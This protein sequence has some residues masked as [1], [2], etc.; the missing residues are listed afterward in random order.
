V[1]VL[2]YAQPARE[3]IE[4][5]PIGNGLQGAMLFGGID[6]ERIQINEGTAWSGSTRSERLPPVVPAE[7]AA[8]AV[9]R[10]RAALRRGDHS[11]A[12]AQVRRLQH[13]YS[14]TF[15]PFA[16]LEV[17]LKP[18]GRGAWA[19]PARRYAR[20]LDLDA[21]LHTVRYH[22]DGIAVAQTAFASWPDRV[23]VHRVRTDRPV[24]V[25]LVL[26]SPLRTLSWFAPGGVDHGSEVLMELGL[27]LQL[28]SD[29]APPHEDV[30]EPITWDSRE[31]AALRGAAVV[32]VRHDGRAAPGRES[33][34]VD[35]H[36]VTE[37][38]IVIATATTFRGLGQEA[39]GDEHRA[40]ARAVASVRAAVAHGVGNVRRRQLADHRSLYR[41]TRWETPAADA[42]ERTTDRL[43]L[44]AN[45]G[46]EPLRAAPQLAPQLF[47]YGRYLMISASRR[48]GTPAN[49]QGIWNQE[50]R[51]PW[52]ANYTADINLQMN[53][54]AADVADLPEVLP[55]LFDLVAAL[56]RNGA[57]TARRL[58]GA[59]GWVAHHNTD[60]WAHTQPVGFGQH[61][62]KWAF[63]PFAGA[64]LVRHLH[65]HLSFGARSADDAE[66][67]AAEVVW[68]VTRAAAEF[69][70]D[71]LIEED[72]G[73]L[74]TAPSTSPENS[75]AAPDGATASVARSATM[76]LAL[77]AELLSSLEDLAERLGRA[78]DE[79]VCRGREALARIP[80][81]P[82]AKDGTVQEWRDDLTAT[83]PR[84]RHQSH[85]Y[86]VYP[87]T[88]AL[89]EELLRAASRSLDER[90]DDSTGWSLAC[91]PTCSQPT[92]RSRSTPTSASWPPW[93]SASCRAT[94]A[95][96]RCCPRCP[97]SSP[98]DAS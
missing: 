6:A 81:P 52:S 69:V 71:W 88:G 58:Y 61:D 70:L 82:V 56:S 33:A 87:G 45:A 23:L 3:W 46:G 25:S 28:P 10:A 20:T 64:W 24:D 34:S 4:A 73:S 76:D 86:P 91:T 36:A 72:D 97:K 74:G 42:V 35:L 85:L 51:P 1:H 16:D 14:Q 65:D 94:T 57:E 47:H 89:S 12:D 63:W 43:L 22:R 30:A 78:D 92:R 83:D 29:V 95:A 93:P 75:F 53:Y 80:G 17:R 18:A 9:A 68:P 84:H 67:F 50:M 38:D 77:A 44:E 60:V 98:P 27:L 59:R 21:A 55:P 5:L 26:S 7:Q 31:G 32:G 40:S 48:G 79:V 66:A 11:E 96:S 62:P 19:G 54:W 15:V 37:V 41:R 49:L 13:R 39:H 8:D 90:G 2:R